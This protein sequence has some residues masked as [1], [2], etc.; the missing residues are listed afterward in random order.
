MIVY[1]HPFQVAV[2]GAK[3]L[4]FFILFFFSPPQHGHDSQ[5]DDFTAFNIHNKSCHC[6]TVKTH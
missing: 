6:N 1:S 5:H 4:I 2:H 3:T